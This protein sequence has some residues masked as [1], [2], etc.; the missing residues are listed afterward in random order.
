MK[1]PSK[2]FTFSNI[3]PNN[4]WY[5]YR[6]V[7]TAVKKRKQLKELYPNYIFLIKKYQSI[8]YLT[9]VKDG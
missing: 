9:G 5:L 3:R 6:G 7:A 1:R 4:V 2:Q 8:F